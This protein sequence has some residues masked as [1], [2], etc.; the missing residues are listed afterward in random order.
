MLPR[1]S[2][3]AMLRVACKLTVVALYVYHHK[4]SDVCVHTLFTCKRFHMLVR[5][6]NADVRMTSTHEDVSIQDTV[7]AVCIPNH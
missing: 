2:H 3:C 6:S 1:P 4:V 7:L 5:S